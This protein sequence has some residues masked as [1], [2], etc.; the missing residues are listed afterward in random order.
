M[1][2]WR[3][4]LSLYNSVWCIS[5]CQNFYLQIA[6][7]FGEFFAFTNYCF[8]ALLT[9]DYISNKNWCDYFTWYNITNYAFSFCIIRLLLWL[10]FNQVDSNECFCLSSRIS[11]HRLWTGLYSCQKVDEWNAGKFFSHHCNLAMSQY[12]CLMTL[13]NSF[14][15]LKCSMQKSP[16]FKKDKAALFPT[17]L[18]I[19]HT[20][21]QMRA[22]MSTLTLVVRDCTPEN[23]SVS[24]SSHLPTSSQKLET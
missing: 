19:V 20:H 8:T 2:G 12:F 18:Y 5:A 3:L 17:A 11:Y 13:A 1:W 14:V 23:A 21:T 24:L 7:H 6:C 22:R 4:F 16:S 15:P 9:A 10:C